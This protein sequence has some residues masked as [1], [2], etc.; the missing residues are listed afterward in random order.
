MTRSPFEASADPAPET[1]PSAGAPAVDTT[2]QDASA[3]PYTGVFTDYAPSGA[4]TAFGLPRP[5]SLPQ[6]EDTLRRYEARINRVIDY[7]VAD[8]ARDF[9]LDELAGA[10][11]FSPFHF[12]RIFAGLVGE[13]LHAFIRRLRMDRAANMLAFAPALNVTDVAMDCGFSSSQNFARAFR[14]RFAMTPSEYRRRRHYRTGADREGARCLLAD[15]FR[16]HAGNGK[17][18]NVAPGDP[19]YESSMRDG[20]AGRDGTAC[21]LAHPSEPSGSPTLPGTA[22]PHGDV[23]WL[24]D[25]PPHVRLDPDS[26]RSDAM[27][28]EV[29]ERPACRVAYLRHIGPYAGETIGPVWG[30]LMAWAGQRGL[31][32][33]GVPGF[34]VSWDNPEVTP[35]ENC[36]YDACIAI[37]PEVDAL[38][39]AEAGISVQTLPGGLYAEYRS[40]ISCDG[41]F[42][43]WNDMYAQWLPASGWQ[44]DDRPGYELYH[45]MLGCPAEGPWDVGI[46]VAVRPL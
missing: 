21:A 15:P 12:H 29:A 9:T 46:C 26:T 43:A 1:A 45:D 2:G 44:C 24:A 37:G 7:I 18:R 35:P 8:P 10:A 32:R 36:R 23:P 16:A 22:P 19:G 6:R 34:G 30:R 42:R 17:A 11:P 41:F 3:P 27:N 31:M 38:E 14:E 28:V 4:E 25:G 13:T 40:M 33:P 20:A 39:L 5:E